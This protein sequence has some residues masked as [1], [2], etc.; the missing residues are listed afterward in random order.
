MLY[1]VLG[2]SAGHPVSTDSYGSRQDT[3]SLTSE[4]LS[5]VPPPGAPDPPWSSGG[6]QVLSDG[7]V[8]IDAGYYGHV[9]A[10]ILGGYNGVGGAALKCLSGNQIEF[11]LWAGQLQVWMDGGCYWTFN[12][13]SGKTFVIDH[14][15]DIDKNLVHACLEGPEVA[16]FHRGATR[17]N[18]TGR[19]QVQMP[20]YFTALVRQSTVQVFVT[21]VLVDEDDA[22]GPVA[23]TRFS[24][25][26]F[27]IRGSAGQWVSWLIIAT[28]RDVKAL[29]VEPNRNAIRVRGQGP[30]RWVE[31]K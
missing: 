2:Q 5:Q 13:G 24:Q 1:S 16:V 31:E 21:P 4:I 30:Y 28:R 15:T 14:P 27:V 3:S 6:I 20:A 10:G 8:G 22:F 25:G 19:A 12:Q 11:S 26:G 29:E 23:A 9:V 18:A 7:T 17:L